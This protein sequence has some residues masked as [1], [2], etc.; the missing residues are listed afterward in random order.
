M[1]RG[2]RMRIQGAHG[3]RLTSSGRSARL[4]PQRELRAGE[5]DLPRGAAGEV[6]AI[7]GWNG[8]VGAHACAPRDASG[9]LNTFAMF[10]PLRTALNVTLRVASAAPSCT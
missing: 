9:R 6:V 2:S 4:L 5:T 7:F 8:M 1:R 10:I 3:F